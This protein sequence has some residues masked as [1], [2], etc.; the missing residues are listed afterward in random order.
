MTTKRKCWDY[1]RFGDAG[2]FIYNDK[3]NRKIV[4]ITHRLDTLFPVCRCY[5]G[6][7]AVFDIEGIEVI[8]WLLKE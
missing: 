6:E 4:R 1:I 7:E 2:D 5:E 8:E 3:N